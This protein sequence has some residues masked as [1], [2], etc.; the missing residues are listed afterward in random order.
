VDTPEPF[1][2]RGRLVAPRE[3]IEDGALVVDGA[4]LAWVGAATQVPSRWRKLVAAVPPSDSLLLPGLVDLHNHGGGGAS[5]PEASDVD[6]VRTAVREHLAHGTTSLV[7]SLV[8]APGPVLLERV[9]TL[10]AV[11]A[12][13]ELA[14]IH[15]EGPFLAPARCGA[16]D[17]RA[18]VPGDVTLVHEIAVAAGGAFATMT[19]APEIAG[20]A[21]VVRALAEVGAVPSIGHSDATAAETRASIDAA[22]A[23]LTGPGARSGRPT[24][25]HLFNGM[26]P[27]H[28]REPGPAGECLA[29]ASRGELVVELVADGVHL[30]DETTTMVFDLVGA[31]SI[32]LV[33]D[34]MAATGMADGEYVLGGLAVTV[35]GGVARLAEGG[36]IAGGTA[37]LL[38]VVRRTVRLGVPLEDAV[39]AASG[40]PASVLGR[41]DLGA[42]AE[43][44]LADVLV[45]DADLRVREVF[46]D[47]VRVVG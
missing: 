47:G 34:A 10:A 42:L 6:G 39:R 15:L 1:A 32:A 29:A 5:F 18:M 43:G 23:A 36:A 20:S 17:P 45:A 44:Y 40:T 46:R 19:Y 35:H 11:V 16:Q 24:A 8:T 13:G 33:T 28:H 26:R 14:A 37:H 27:L 12:A 2:L 41:P 9:R 31:D 30:A 3:V 4:R 38:D 22:R 7:A 21:H 25:T